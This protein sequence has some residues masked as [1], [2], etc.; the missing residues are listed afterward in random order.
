MAFVPITVDRKV[1]QQG[2]ANIIPLSLA[3]ATTGAERRTAGI[4]SKGVAGVG[5]ELAEYAQKH[6][7][8]D[9]AIDDAAFALHYKNT[10]NEARNAAE[11]TSN[12][13]D[14]HSI[15]EQA[16]KKVADYIEGRNE[17]GTPNIRWKD[18]ADNARLKMSDI[19]AQSGELAGRRVLDIHKADSKAK[20]RRLA[21][22]FI[23]NEDAEG[24]DRLGPIMRESGLYTP[25]QVNEVIQQGQATIAEKS[26]ARGYNALTASMA[27]L[28]YRKETGEISTAQEIDELNRIKDEGIG[29]VHEDYKNVLESRVYSRLTKAYKQEKTELNNGFKRLAK[30]LSSGDYTKDDLTYFLGAHVSDYDDLVL[31]AQQAKQTLEEFKPTGGAEGNAPAILTAIENAMNGEKDGEPYAISD[32][33]KD[34]NDA[35]SALAPMGLIILGASMMADDAG[36]DEEG[37]HN[38]WNVNE[39]A[40]W[41]KKSPVKVSP[42]S[43]LGETV[44]MMGSYIADG[45]EDASWVEKTFLKAVDIQDST[46]IPEDQKMSK[47]REL[48]KGRSRL[49]AQEV[50]SPQIQ[51]RES[52]QPTTISTK[53]EFDALPSGALYIDS[54]DGKTYRK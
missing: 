21:D 3:G 4:I 31:S 5:A 54:E 37:F 33:I 26:K 9:I 38:N 19:K 44:R 39:K 13:D 10:M 53:E 28:A 49:V 47:V 15:Y 12:P 30:G 35:N 32:A 27:E 43:L 36:A 48:F 2:P 22:E 20:H 14:V 7:E 50:S 8:H 29:E 1:R 42:D 51:Q 40:G 25:E 34:M 24:F 23:A 11:M 52:L 46:E 18:H 6:K 16:N 45:D 41:F 17:E